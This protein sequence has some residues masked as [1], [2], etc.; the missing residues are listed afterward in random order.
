ME[1]DRYDALKDRFNDDYGH[2]TEMNVTNVLYDVAETYD[3]V[4]LTHDRKNRFMLL[5]GTSNTH[6]G[7]PFKQEIETLLQHLR[8][9]CSTY[10]NTTVT[11]GISAAG[12]GYSQIKELYKESLLALEMKFATGEGSTLWYS[13]EGVRQ[14]R[15]RIREALVQLEASWSSLDDSLRQALSEQVRKFLLDE[16]YGNTDVLN[17]FLRLMQVSLLSVRLQEDAIW[18]LHEQASASIRSA[19][20]I[21][22]AAGCFEDYLSRL[23]RFRVATPQWSREVKEAV[24]FMEM[25]YSQAITLQQLAKHVN[26]SPAYFSTLFKKETTCSPIDYLIQY[27]I[28]KAKELLLESDSRTYEIAEMVGIPDH[29]YFSR[30]FKKM[31]GMNPKSFR[32]SADRNGENSYADQP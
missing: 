25:H 22:E 32:I 9:V 27:R 3:Y 31:T 20:T 12:S 17:F 24:R 10:F 26:L 18:T 13:Q 4:Q 7:D 8:Q 19:R 1:I 30:I 6:G 23:I 16:C 11:F 2:L 28:G 15:D 29:S 5:I 14:M 21:W